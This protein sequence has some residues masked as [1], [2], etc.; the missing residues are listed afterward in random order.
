MLKTKLLKVSSSEWKSILLK[1]RD[2]HPMLNK[3]KSSQKGFSKEDLCDEV[4]QNQHKRIIIKITLERS[5][6][7]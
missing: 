5:R 6:N 1:A 3:T 4:Y 2:Y 7:T